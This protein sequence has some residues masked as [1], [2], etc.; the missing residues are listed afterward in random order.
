MQALTTT[1]HRP[2]PLPPCVRR[3]DALQAECRA[4]RAELAAA[5]A[6]RDS[7]Q[8]ST[9]GGGGAQDS[10]RARASAAAAAAVSA[11]LEE[12]ASVVNCVF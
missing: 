3:R 11:A 5:A 8:P 4:L 1:P 10:A 9:A 6:A 7:A 2:L 12:Q